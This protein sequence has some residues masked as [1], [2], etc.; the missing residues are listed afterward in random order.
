MAHDRTRDTSSPHRPGV[1]VVARSHVGLR[2]SENQDAHGE[3]RRDSDV[4]VVVA[5][6]MGGAA[7]GATASRIAV[8]MVMTRS[9]E[10]RTLSGETLAAIVAEANAAIIAEAGRTPDLKGMGTTLVA[11]VITPRDGGEAD[12]RIINIGDSRA[13]LWSSGTLRQITSDHSIVGDMVARGEISP[14]EARTHPRR[15][16]ILRA[17]GIDATTRADLFD[18]TLA[19]DDILLLC[20]DGLHGMASDREIARILATDW[21]LQTKCDSLV[22]AALDGGGDDNVTVTLAQLSDDESFD[23]D[24]TL[25]GM[26]R[27]IGGDPA[28]EGGVKPLRIVVVILLLAGLVWSLF[29]FGVVGGGEQAGIDSLGVDDSV[30]FIP[31]SLQKTPGD[32][33]AGDTLGAD[34]TDSNATP[35]TDTTSSLPTLE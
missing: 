20:S 8:D 2:R 3:M 28:D 24:T 17:L 1:R 34:T 5:D 16:V 27:Y 12:A 4:V 13:Y 31:D 35:S 6:G 14:E 15:N 30:G 29:Q 33:I 32:I 18:L 10:R 22:E 25:T 23:D 11:A 19:G 9:R 7:G 21:D 26:R